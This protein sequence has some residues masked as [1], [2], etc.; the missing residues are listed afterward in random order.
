MEIEA[1]DP[2]QPVRD[3][4]YLGLTDAVQLRCIQRAIDILAYPGG[5]PRNVAPR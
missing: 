4:P 1:H 5:T 2:D 3:V